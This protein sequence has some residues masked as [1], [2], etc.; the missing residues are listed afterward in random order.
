M[1]K[2]EINESTFQRLQRWAIPLVDSPESVV[3]RV[4]DA[5]ERDLARRKA[6]AI[7][8][9]SASENPVEGAS[10]PFSPSVSRR[11][12]TL[13]ALLR[14][15]IVTSGSRL[16]LMAERIPGMAKVDPADIRFRCKIGPQPTARRNII[17]DKDGRLYSLS[18]LTELLR[19]QEGVP[20]SLGALNGYWYW[21]VD[22]DTSN[23]LW[24]LAEAAGRN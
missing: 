16:V 10:G 12:R 2:L 19:D 6:A 3:I 21:A 18:A 5:A 9:E 22:Y 15:G 1:I 23:A 8:P 20:L 11:E 7:P 17:W 14:K 13:H 4:L 24:D